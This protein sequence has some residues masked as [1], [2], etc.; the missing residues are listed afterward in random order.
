MKYTYNENGVCLNPSIAFRTENPNYG[1]LEIRVSEKESNWTFG[2][3][4]N[5]N[6]KG[7]GGGSSGCSF[8][9]WCTFESEEKAIV[10][11]INQLKRMQY[12][13]KD[14][15]CEWHLQELIKFEASRNQLTLF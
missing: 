6:H 1:N 3:S 11:A 10:A 13:E 15:S 4:Y 9:K 8:F 2:Y 14:G 7:Q 5:Y 12:F